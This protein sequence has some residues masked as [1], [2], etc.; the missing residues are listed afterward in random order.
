MTTA[1]II[2]SIRLVRF[3]IVPALTALS[4]GRGV[5]WLEAPEGAALPYVIAQSQD[6]GGRGEFVIGAL[7][8]SGPITVKALARANG[9]GNA[10][11]AA[12]ALME[13]VAPGMG[14]LTA[15]AGYAIGAR[16]VRPVVIPP[17]D[18]VWQSAHTWRVRLERA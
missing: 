14:S 6:A 5:Y 7:A 4:G 17:L 11:A 9:S 16:Y 13:L 15:P 8:W 12:E 10:Q 1:P 2:E 3:A 18:G